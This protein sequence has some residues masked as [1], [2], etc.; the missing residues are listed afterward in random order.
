MPVFDTW[1]GVALPI[2]AVP[3]AIAPVRTANGSSTSYR[4]DGWRTTKDRGLV[5][6]TDGQKAR[7]V[8]K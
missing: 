4:L 7:K 5:I 6:E 2:D 8:I 1:T 3:T